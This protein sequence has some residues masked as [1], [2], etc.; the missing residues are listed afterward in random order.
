MLLNP[1]GL[2]EDEIIKSIHKYNA[3]GLLGPISSSEDLF[4]RSV[5]CLFNP[6]CFGSTL[7][8]SFSVDE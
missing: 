8:G 4:Q 2:F 7:I 3:F 6:M 5:T 1:F